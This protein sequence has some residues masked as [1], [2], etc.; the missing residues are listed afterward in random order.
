MKKTKMKMEKYEEYQKEPK[1]YV[2][3]LNELMLEK[4]ATDMYL[5]YNEPPTL[6]IMEEVHRQTD[7][8]KLDDTMLNKIALALMSKTGLDYFEKYW[9]LDLWVWY[10]ERRYRVN[11]S[12]QR[13]HVMIVSRL[14][15]NTI[16]TLGALWLPPIFKQLAYRENGIVFLAWPTWSWKSTTL[17]AVIEEINMHKKKHILTI[18]DPIEYIFEPKESII[19]QKELGKDVSSFTDAMKYALRQ[20]PD[21]ILFW[22]IRDLESIRNAILLSETW[23]LVLTTVH[24]RSSEQALNKIIGS[25][26]SEEQSHIRTQLSENMAA[27]VVQKLLKRQDKPGLVLWQEILINTTAVTNI[28]RENKLNQLKSV[29]YTNRVSWWMQLMEESLISLFEE[30]KISLEQALE[31]ANDPAYIKRE[32]INKGYLR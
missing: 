6:R 25:F 23:H 16:P 8:P 19:D 12:R 14:L 17:A 27:I 24:A 2:A 30:K 28:I 5:T 29:M 9:A 11:I 15:R 26:P 32:L 3:F 13:G 4:N 1:K 10:K 7:L 22:E 21:V 31:A 20:R 18:E